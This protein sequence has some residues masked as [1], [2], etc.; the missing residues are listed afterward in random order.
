MDSCLQCGSDL[1]KGKHMARVCSKC[2][3]ENQIEDLRNEIHK[4]SDCVVRWHGMIGNPKRVECE[5]TYLYYR[6]V[7]ENLVDKLAKLK[8]EQV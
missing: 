1:G 4:A 5:K 8:S 6:S 2:Q 3:Q 7:L